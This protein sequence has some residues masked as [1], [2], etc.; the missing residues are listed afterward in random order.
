LVVVVVCVVFVVDTGVGT[1]PVNFVV[2]GL[3]VGS[4]P[5]TSP[6]FDVG[7]VAAV[8]GVGVA[9]AGDVLQSQGKQL[10]A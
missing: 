4:V 9:Q 10:H 8:A 5:D 6:I 7:A 1:L 3:G 2:R